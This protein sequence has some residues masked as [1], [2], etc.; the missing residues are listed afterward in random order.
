MIEP[1]ATQLQPFTGVH[2]GQIADDGQQRLAVGIGQH[3]ARDRPQ[4]QDGVA[5]LLVV[6]GDALHGA[7]DLCPVDHKPILTICKNSTQNAEEELNAKTPG[8][9][10]ARYKLAIASL[11]PGVFALN[12]S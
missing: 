4:P 1:L 10:D 9:K 5:V 12:F 11:R 8:R 2:F 7:A 6:I 3:A